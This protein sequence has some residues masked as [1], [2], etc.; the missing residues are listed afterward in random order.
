MNLSKRWLHDYVNI[1][2]T[3]KQFADALTIS[4]SKVEAYETEGEELSNIV[5]ARVESLEKHPDSDHLWICQVNVGAEENLQIV[6]GAQ[7]LKAGDY[8][9]AALDNSVVA[10]G[11]KI[12][13][14][15][16]R[17]VESAGML[18]SLGELGLTVNDFPNAIEDGIFVLGEDCNL[19]LGMDIREATGFND[20]V[21]E[22]EITS[23]RPDCLSVLGLARETAVTFGMDFS[24]PVPVV[25]PGE[26][27]V[28]DLL[29]VSIE[30]PEL[31]YRYVGAVVKNVKIEPSPRWMRERL[32]A[33][34]VRPINNIVDITNFVMLEYGQPMHAFDLRY[35]EG[36]EVIVRN[37]KQGEKITTLDGIEREL[38]EEMLVIADANKPVAVAGVMGGEYSGIMDDTNTIVFESACF[39]GPSIR[40]TAKKLG[41][42]TEASSRYDKQLDPKGCCKILDRAL[43]L[44]QQLGAG[45]VVN[46]VVDCD[47]SDKSDFTLAFE[48]DWVNEFIG[49]NV[50][51][52]E[53]KIILERLGCKVENGIITVPSF[54]G[55]LRHKADISE[56]I[57]RFYG[58]D[59]I[60]DRQ[61]AG[62]AT[63]QYTPEQKF[64]RLIN[65]TML[66]CGLS[67]LC[68]FS[69]ISPKS[70][71]KICLP[72]DSDKRKCVVISNPLGEDTS[73]MRT[74]MLPSMLETLA[75][76]YNNR[77]AKAYLYELGKEYIWKGADELPAEPQMLC[78]GMYG[79]GC[80]FF[81]IKGIVEELLY[82]LGIEDYDVEAV[83]D[84]PSYHPGRTA[85]ISND[86]KVIG[87]VGE[88]HPQ[89]LENYGIGTKA[90]AAE[91]SFD[92]CFELS[93]LKRTYKQLPKFPALT[94]DLAFVCKKSEPVLMLEKTIAQAVGK[95]L[96]SI[97]LFDVYE[98]SQIP[99]G[100]KSVAFNLKLR[101]A[102]RTMTDEEADSAMKKAVKALEKL[103]ISLRS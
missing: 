29:K 35:L 99:E 40:M 7:N 20:V 3:D 69:F 55:D 17:G 61:L 34:G 26:G 58:Y 38:S 101:A 27:D 98:G 15:K 86:G 95:N 56:E 57:A 78:M 103:G 66:S 74:T 13:K 83:K 96:E 76:N 39:N 82:K 75:R 67:E 22:F 45:E 6:T 10:G 79:A 64:E 77:N 102:D 97:E 11:K 91:I 81:T 70:Y 48:P 23:N 71:D 51:A 28:N 53:Q 100:M 52:D 31:C 2:V 72:A 92:V 36:N 37:A 1:D 68:T 65:N 63:A 9:P 16:L 84:N 50:S 24:E 88:I 93:Q 46:G 87:T 49:I 25:A 59:K 54:R 8:V 32:R 47:C 33:S 62:V 19:T 5:V 44:V 41:M 21:T 60:P 94:R 80:S 14:G 18:C 4:G 12:K 90:Y 42:R 30:A 89:V 43:Q 85:V 73:V